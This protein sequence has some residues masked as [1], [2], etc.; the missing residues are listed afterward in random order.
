MILVCSDFSTFRD[1]SEIPRYLTDARG[2]C[3]TPIILPPTPPASNAPPDEPSA[4]RDTFSSTSSPQRQIH[5][6]HQYP[7]M[8]TRPGP[9]SAKPSA[10]AARKSEFDAELRKLVE[11][12]R[13][14]GWTIGK[15]GCQLAS[16]A[17]RQG[18]LDD[19]D[20]EDE[21]FGSEYDAME[22]EDEK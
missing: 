21:V 8:P 3:I 17:R 22:V 4:L 10:K 6:A 5:P 19:E 13:R 1:A 18:F 14:V 9:P 7:A 12:Q 15:M 16:E 2:R 11:E 20:F